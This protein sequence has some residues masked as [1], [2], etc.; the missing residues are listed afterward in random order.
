[1]KLSRLPRILKNLV[2]DFYFGGSLRGQE[3]TKFAH[4]GAHNI[5]AADY[6]DLDRIF[7]KGTIQPNETLVDLGSGKGRVLNWWAMKHGQHNKIVGVEID[8]HWA[9]RSR[10]RLVRYPAVQVIDRKSVV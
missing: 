2:I 3:T 8:P 4:L 9:E 1:M 7:P 5:G 6:D 10:A